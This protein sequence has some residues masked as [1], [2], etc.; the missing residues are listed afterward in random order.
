MERQLD[1]GPWPGMARWWNAQGGRT[2]MAVAVASVFALASLLNIAT[3]SL[4]TTTN[5]A[6]PPVVASAALATLPVLTLESAPTDPAKTWNVTGVWQGTGSQETQPFTVA[7]HWR[8]DWLFS[9]VQSGGI[10]QVFIY[11][12]DGRVLMNLAANSQKSGADSSFWAGPGRYF[13]RVNSTGG[14]WKL[15]VQDQR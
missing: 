5:R 13:L 14:D 8:V 3:A 6:A 10:L 15:A 12:A 9:P 4:R 2:K 7:E 1:T 11:H